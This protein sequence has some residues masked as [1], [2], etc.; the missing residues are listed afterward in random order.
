LG[1]G[2]AFLLLASCQQPFVVL[3]QRE[4]PEAERLLVVAS[5]CP[6]L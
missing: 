4:R 3:L 6:S 5:V 2:L 1:P